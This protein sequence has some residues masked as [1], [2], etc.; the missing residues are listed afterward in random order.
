M[1]CHFYK[2]HNFDQEMGLHFYQLV[3]L[4]GR[5]NRKF[6]VLPPLRVLGVSSLTLKLNLVAFS[7]FNKN[8][9]LRS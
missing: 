1:F 5:R 2:F 9:M 6:K 8:V 4:K 7:S 3:G